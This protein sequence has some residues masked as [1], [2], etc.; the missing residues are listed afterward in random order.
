MNP[1]VKIPTNLSV[2]NA[3]LLSARKR[4]CVGKEVA[5][6]AANN[7]PMDAH[8]RLVTRVAD[9]QDDILGTI[10]LVDG[11]PRLEDRLFEQLVDLLVEGMFLDLRERYLGGSIERDAYVDQLGDLAERCRSA[12]LLPLPSRQA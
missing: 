5:S 9:E 11:D 2:D 1:L 3:T 12:G 8:E 7:G 10:Q 6:E 4:R